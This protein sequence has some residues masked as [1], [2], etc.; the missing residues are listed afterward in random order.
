M[1]LSDIYQKAS[2][3][4]IP[5][6]YKSG[7]L[8][9]VVPNTAD[10]DFTVTGD[11]EGE[12]TRVNKDGL[13]E[14]VAANVPRL[15]YPLL[16]GVVQDCPTLLL[17]PTRTNSITYS[18]DFSDS[19][20]NKNNATVTSNNTTAPDGTTNADKITSTGTA[21][22]ARVTFTHSTLTSYAVSIFA[23]KG[24]EDYLYIRA[25]ALSNQPIASFN[26]STGSLGTV[27]SGL[28]AE[29]QNYGNGWY[30]CVI[31]YT[32][33]SSITNNLIDFG[34]AS[35]DNSR[36]SSSGKFTYFWGAQIETGSYAT[37]YIPTSGSAVTRSADVC[38]NAGNSNV[39]ND[40][41]GVLYAEIAALANDGTFRMITVSDGTNDNRVR[42]NYTST[43][44]QIQS[45]VIDGGSTV[46]DFNHTLTD[47]TTSV[48]VA[49]KYKANDCSMWVNGSEVGTDTSATMPSGLDTLNF[50]GGAGTNDFYGKVKDIKVYNTALSDSEL[51]ALTT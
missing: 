50:D 22:Y 26:L 47:I 24:D 46:V 5:S 1:A 14:T 21:P 34:F 28:T 30:R 32:T 29:M 31:K 8:Y 43:S 38:N 12:A 20:W 13:I 45:R 11:P 41:E 3:V 51:Q 9:S 4:Q 27:N 25:L 6:G 48:K 49:I 23:K 17:E 10:G 40:S 44:N 15:D 18:E 19:S 16:D 35:S 39:F 7:T 42:I 36:F 2:L 33:T 37:S